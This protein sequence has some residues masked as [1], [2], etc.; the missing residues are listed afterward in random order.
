M[1]GRRIYST[2]TGK[3][4]KETLNV[5]GSGRFVQLLGTKRATGYGYSL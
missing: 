5:T 2:T 1:P 3:G 4:G